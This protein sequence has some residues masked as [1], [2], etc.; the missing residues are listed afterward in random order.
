MSII[1]KAKAALDTNEDGTVDATEVAG[2]VIGRLKETAAAA[3][4]A[5]GEVKKGF[6]ADE[7]GKVSLDEVKAVGQGIASKASGFVDGIT[8]KVKSE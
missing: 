4:E 7:D 6:D 5:A 2:A 8:S 1:D 3:A